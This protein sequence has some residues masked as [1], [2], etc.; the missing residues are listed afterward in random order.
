[1]RLVIIN[2][3]ICGTSGTFFWY[4]VYLKTYGFLFGIFFMMLSL[5]ITY[6][7]TLFILEASEKSNQNDYLNLI[8]HF[9]GPKGKMCATIT[10]IIDYFS[11]YVIGFLITYNI[12]LYLLYYWNFLD[13]SVFIKNKFLYFN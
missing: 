3:T 12:L 1:M 4:P 11:T 6:F 10:F 7:T 5:S 13:D 2:L 9:L 8:G